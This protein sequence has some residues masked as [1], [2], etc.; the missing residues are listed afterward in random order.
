M[1]IG[2]FG[3]I[4]DDLRFVPQLLKGLLHTAQIAHAIVD[5]G[6]HDAP[7]SLESSTRP[8]SCAR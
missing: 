4:G 7:L 6:D 2:E 1:G 5:D 8:S 3:R